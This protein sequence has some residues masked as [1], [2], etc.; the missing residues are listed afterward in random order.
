[1]HRRHVQSVYD[2]ELF[3]YNKNIHDSLSISMHPHK[4]WSTLETFF[5]CVSSLPSIRTD[6]GSVT[7]KMTKVFSTVFQIKQR[8]MKNLF[9]EGFMNLLIL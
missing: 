7:S 6:D 8:S 4:W 5:W 9:L 3:E 2:A 1:M